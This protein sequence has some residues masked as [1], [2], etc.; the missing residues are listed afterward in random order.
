MFDRVEHEL[1]QL[2]RVVKKRPVYVRDFLCNIYAIFQRLFRVTK[3]KYKK[4][5][6]FHRLFYVYV[7]EPLKVYTCMCACMRACAC[8]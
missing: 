2:P 6:K 4:M 1:L 5:F 7:Y 3:R 8:V